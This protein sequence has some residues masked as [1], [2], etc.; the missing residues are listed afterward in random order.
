M[1]M[2]RRVDHQPSVGK[3]AEQVKITA[4]IGQTQNDFFPSREMALFVETKKV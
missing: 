2:A 3:R 4:I 1:G